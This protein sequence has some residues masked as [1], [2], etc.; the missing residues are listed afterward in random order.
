M[1][2]EWSENEINAL[3]NWFRINNFENKWRI[4][5]RFIW[6]SIYNFMIK[7]K[8]TPAILLRRLSEL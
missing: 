5:G 1:F 6:N 8:G 7:E 3:G 4:V 2:E